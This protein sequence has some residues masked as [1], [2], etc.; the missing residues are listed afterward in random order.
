MKRFGLL[1]GVLSALA[2]CSQ[3]QPP[4]TDAAFSLERQS[5]GTTA[6]DRGKELAF[7]P[8]IGAIYVAGITRGSL[9]F[10][11]RGGNDIYI[12]RYNRNKT[13]VW[14]RQIASTAN[15]IVKDI[16][17]DSGGQLYV[18]GRQ[19]DLCFH[20]KYRA[21]G[22]LLWKHTYSFCSDMAMAVDGTG[23]IYLTERKPDDEF[24]TIYE[25][26]LRKY[27]SRGMQVYSA[28]I[29]T[30]N[31][32]GYPYL[33]VRDVAIDGEGNAYVY[34]VD[35]DDDCWDYIQKVSPSGSVSSPYMFAM[36]RSSYGENGY[37]IDNH[38]SALK[39]VGNA[40]Y[41]VGDK[42]YYGTPE[43]GIFDNL[44]ESDI[45]VVKYTLDGAISWKRTFGT[46]VRDVGT[47]VTADTAGNVYAVG[48]TRGSL[49][50]RNAGADDILM[51]KLS[52][53]GSTLWTKQ[54]GN[55]SFD[56]ANDI[57]TYS[58]SELY[59]TGTTSGALEGSTYH[60]RK[61]AFLLRRNGRGDRVWTDQ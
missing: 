18:G 51:R 44:L 56:Q 22:L 30:N 55:A 32:I 31:G 48:V 2:A 19:G 10:S 23:N 36:P 8:R 49:A 11:N 50:A 6:D 1:L 13:V 46:K 45:L 57:I 43:Y 9:D 28:A 61:D 4:A 60:G 5:L 24:D 40:L 37:I 58:S 54:F 29:T 17:A 47:T 25:Y 27:N 26:E 20:S 42:S 34:A 7:A 39:V 52:A 3:V 41:A 16:A 35:C 33:G 14:S 12:R 15:D 59:L 38:Y 21:D 53:S